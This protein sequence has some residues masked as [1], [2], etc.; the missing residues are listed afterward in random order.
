ME[1]YW[2]EGVYIPKRALKKAHKG[3]QALRSSLEPFARSLW[4]VSQ[5]DAL[6]LATEALQGGQWV[7]PPRVSQTSEERLMRS[8]GAPELPG[9]FAP[10][11]RARKK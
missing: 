2:V 6:R 1:S 4:A 5:E 11:K 10:S 7:E 9:L 8:L 3:G